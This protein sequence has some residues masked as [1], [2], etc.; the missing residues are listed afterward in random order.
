MAF[1]EPT[2]IQTFLLKHTGEVAV[3]G[4]HY[5]PDNKKSIRVLSIPIVAQSVNKCNAGKLVSEWFA[6]EGQASGCRTECVHRYVCMYVCMYVCRVTRLG[7][8]S[9]NG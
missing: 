4:N 6:E 3:E 5:L 8:F 2:D 7:E 1:I 9:P